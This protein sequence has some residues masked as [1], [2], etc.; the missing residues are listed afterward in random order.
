MID[1]KP[2]ELLLGLRIEHGHR[3]PY[4]ISHGRFKKVDESQHVGNIFISAPISALVPII[5]SHFCIEIGP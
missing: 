4:G 2:Q 1:L 3:H 5:M